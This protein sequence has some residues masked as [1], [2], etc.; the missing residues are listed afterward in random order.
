M[1][2]GS[3][4]RVTYLRYTALTRPK[5]AE[6][7]AHCCD[8]ALS[9]LVMLVPRNVFHVVSALQSMTSQETA[10]PARHRQSIANEISVLFSTIIITALYFPCGS[11][12][13]ELIYGGF[14]VAKKRVWTK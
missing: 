6:T 3:L 9:V 5:K 10:I 7:A 14:P 11:D 8:P 1:C 13:S 12:R 4:A 2:V